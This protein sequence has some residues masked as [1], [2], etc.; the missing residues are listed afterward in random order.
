M[1]TLPSAVKRGTGSPDVP[2]NECRIVNGE[3]GR[4]VTPAGEQGHC[5]EPPF[6]RQIP[7]ASKDIQRQAVSTLTPFQPSGRQF[8]EC[9]RLAKGL[10]CGNKEAPRVD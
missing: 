1:I 8:I 4:A 7:D 5:H 6:R 9:W 3:E 10:R 2:S